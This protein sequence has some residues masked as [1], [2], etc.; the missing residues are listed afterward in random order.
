MK[1]KIL[2]T[3]ALSPLHAGTGQGIGVIDLPIAREKATGLPFLPGSSVKGSLRDVCDDKEKQKNLFGPEKNNADLH[4][5]SVQFSD[6]RLLLL[7]VRSLKGTFAWVTSPYILNRFVRDARDADANSLIKTVPTPL[8]NEEVQ[9][10]FVIDKNKLE[11][12]DDKGNLK[13]YLEDLDLTVSG[14]KTK[15]QAW[16]DVF[17]NEIFTGDWQ[18]FFKE[19]FCIVP[20]DVLNFLL[21]TATEIT[22]RISINPE[23]KTAEDGQL[24]YEEALP[25]ETVLFGLALAVKIGKETVRVEPEVALKEISNLIAKPVQFGGKATVGRGLCRLT[26]SKANGGAI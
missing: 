9:E 3:H 20:D 12:K 10:C 21:D 5:G 22:A 18:S 11:M 14:D 15:A 25:C 13:V 8:S 26:F 19:R 2:Y 6:Q 4:A 1:T 23:T 16:A 7:P 17:A 24:W